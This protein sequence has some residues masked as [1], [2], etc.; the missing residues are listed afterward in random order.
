MGTIYQLDW[1][2]ITWNAELGTISVIQRRVVD[3]L[4]C[5]DLLLAGFPSVSAR[6][7][8]SFAGKV[9]SLS[10]VVGNLVLLRTR[11]TYME[12]VKRDHWDK[13][14]RL[15]HDSYVFSE[16]LFWKSN[17]V[18]LNCRHLFEY[19]VPEVLIYSD[20]S[21]LG[22]GAWTAQCG[23]LKFFRNWTV[24]ESRKSSTWRELKGVVLALEAFSPS[25]KHKKVKIF[26]DNTG[27]EAV[28]KKGSMKYELQELALYVANLCDSIP[29]ELDV[30]W[31]PRSQNSEADL[32]SRQVDFDDWG[33][34]PEFFKYVDSIWG[35]HTIDRFADEYNSKLP[36]FN[37]KFWCPSTSGVDAFAFDW[38]QEM[39]WLVPPICL[40]AK[41][42][43]H[44]KASRA[45]ATLIVPAWRSAPF[46]PLLFS[47]SSS[48]SHMVIDVVEFPDANGIFVQ[49]R[50]VNSIFGT[51]RMSSGVICV[52]LNGA[53]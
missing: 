42:I 9:I 30:Q 17:L 50:N 48:F 27:V 13:V 45:S 33:V 29:M 41:A 34:S 31:I 4:A 47:P 18:R 12:V 53:V 36:S 38:G 52:K 3:L 46:W 28:L 2:G 21:D 8:A 49:G 37:S 10:P 7:L 26:S 14:F 44:V 43:K 23:E 22:C 20:A 39:N 1:L 24:E 16:V 51:P 19:S 35:P 25:L 6:Q 40:V 15:P 5:I 11:Y 32:L